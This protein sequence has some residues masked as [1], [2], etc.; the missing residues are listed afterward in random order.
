MERGLAGEQSGA[1]NMCCT[2]TRVAGCVCIAAS[3]SRQQ[4]CTPTNRGRI[5][6]F[7]ENSTN[8]GS[9][10]KPQI[11]FPRRPSA[12]ALSFLSDRT[13]RCIRFCICATVWLFEGVVVSVHRLSRR[14]GAGVPAHI[15]RVCARYRCVSTG[16]R[17][18]FAC[19]GVEL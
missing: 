6:A 3:Q 18:E 19:S 8:A 9:R 17:C 7:S 5:M 2:R 14:R 11:T 12:A 10:E 4:Q 13:R 16:P 15:S 1:D